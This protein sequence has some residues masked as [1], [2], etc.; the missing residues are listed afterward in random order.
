MTS[1]SSVDCRS[2]DSND[3]K[4]DSD[5]IVTIDKEYGDRRNSE[6]TTETTTLSSCT[7]TPLTTVTTEAVVS[8][9][10]PMMRSL[11]VT[12][13][14]GTPSE[15]QDVTTAKNAATGDVEEKKAGH[16]FYYVPP[17][18]T[19]EFRTDLARN[20]STGSDCNDQPQQRQSFQLQQDSTFLLARD[21]TLTPQFPS[22][23]MV[24]PP[25]HKSYFHGTNSRET[26][27]TKIPTSTNENQNI[28]FHQTTQPQQRQQQQQSLLTVNQHIAGVPHVYHDYIS[29]TSWNENEDETTSTFIRKKTGGVSQPFPEKLHEMLTTVENTNEKDIVTWL[30]HGRAFI[31]RKPKEFTDFIMPKYVTLCV[32]IYAATTNIDSHSEFSYFSLSDISSKPS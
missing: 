14:T 9:E 17:S 18:T 31:V 32:C 8:I 4:R 20:N 15:L 29:Q 7:D 2:V 19:H 12:P 23:P 13:A 3:A 11:A 25:I 30:P 26:S 28:I 27:V 21:Q 6:T 16:H 10:A 5:K 1:F 24:T 22:S